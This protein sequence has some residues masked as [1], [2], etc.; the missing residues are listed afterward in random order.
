VPLLVLLATEPTNASSPLAL[1]SGGWKRALPA[2]FGK[3][4]ADDPRRRRAQENPV[5]QANQE[6]ARSY[7][8]SAA[9]VVAHIFAPEHDF[10]PYRVVQSG[11]SAC[12]KDAH[13][14]QVP[15][16]GPEMMDEP[17]VEAIASAISKLARAENLDDEVEE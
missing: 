9:P 8:A 12:C 11:W 6:A 14:Y 13:F 2:L 15:C 1:L 7:S 5:Y 16:S 3:K 17:A 10:P 4:P